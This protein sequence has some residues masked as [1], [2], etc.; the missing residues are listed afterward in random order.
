MTPP[1]DRARALSAE[2]T[3][4]HI[5]LRSELAR[6]QGE[7]DA[8]SPTITIDLR[9]HCVAFCSAV[10]RHHVAE[11][12]HAF[13]RLAEQFPEL[14]P[15]LALLAQDH[16]MVAT[17]LQNMQALLESLTDA[18]ADVTRVREGLAGLAAI[19]ESHFAF[20]ERKLLAAL[21]DLR[22]ADAGTLFG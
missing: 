20:E 14:K 9:H 12:A 4:I 18:P 5:S 16:D 3:E 11:D 10:S 6:L 22:D 7:L 1:A 17:L 15:A 21:D 2:L 8:P 19:L 13:P